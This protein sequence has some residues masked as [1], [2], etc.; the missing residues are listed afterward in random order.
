MSR[1]AISVPDLGMQTEEIKFGL[2][3][4]EVGERVAAGEDLFEVEADK[5]TVVCEAL[6]AGIL[7]ET[8]VVEGTVTTG[9]VVGYLDA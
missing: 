4:K 8:A 5:A 2:W 3:L 6:A 9:Q 1:V 7:A